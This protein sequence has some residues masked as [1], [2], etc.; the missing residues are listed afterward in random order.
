MNKPANYRSQPASGDGQPMPSI[1]LIKM[2]KTVT[3]IALGMGLWMVA[4]AVRGQTREQ[5]VRSDKAK[6]EADG[7]WIYNDLALGMTEAKRTN[8]PLIVVL[9]CIPCEECVKLDDELVD[10]NETLRPLLEKFVRVRLISTNGLDL[11]LFQYDTDQSFAVFLLNADGTIYGRFGTRSD[12]RSWADD[13][14]IEGL[15]R[16]LEGALALHAR[17]PAVRDSLAGKRGPAP[18]FPVPEKFP[19][20]SGKYGPKLDYEGNVVRSCIHCHQIGDA[21]REYYRSTSGTIPEQVLF[22]YPHP[23][24]LGLILDPRERASVRR[25]I[26]GSLAAQA[27]FQVNDTLLSLQG[28]PLLSIADMQWVLHHTPAEGGAVRVRLRRG[29][30]TK[31]LTWNLPAGWRRQDDIAWRASS[32]GLRRFAFGGMYLK[33]LT[34]EQRTAARLAPDAFGLYVQHVGQFA[35]HDGAKRAGVRSGDVLIRF[36]DRSDLP[37]ETDLLAYAL[38]TVTPGMTIPITILRN[39]EPLDL[40][41][42]TA[43]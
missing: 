35:P 3:V 42:P 33:P 17:F 40:K 16:A 32:W 31:E 23:K 39:G 41:I 28:Q 24:S 2:K 34:D 14:S 38:E 13:V 18:E 37:R 6:V 26:E 20:L 7:F 9:R 27:G 19:L 30:Q 43:R 22:P 1:M 21:Q 10:Q 5:K 36:A 12:Q 11:S 25:V 4:E 8:Q 15:A 29:E